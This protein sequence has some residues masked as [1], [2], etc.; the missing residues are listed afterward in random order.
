MSTSPLPARV[1]S[2]LLA[3][4]VTGSLLGSMDL[5]AAEQMDLARSALQTSPSNAQLAGQAAQSANCARG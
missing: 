5:I 1:T 2:L 3:A 4:L